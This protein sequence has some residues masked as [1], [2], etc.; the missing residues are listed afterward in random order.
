[1]LRKNLKVL[2]ARP[3][4]RRDNDEE[5]RATWLELYFDLFFVA[6]IGRVSHNF[7]HN[8]AHHFEMRYLIDMSLQFIIIWLMWTMVVYYSERFDMGGLTKR[9]LYFMM[10]FPV[11][12]IA[13]FGAENITLYAPYFFMS[14]AFA[15]LIMAVWVY[16][17]MKSNQEY[18]QVGRINM[19]TNLVTVLLIS[20]SALVDAN[21]SRWIYLLII[22]L[23]LGLPLLARN[24]ERNLSP[25]VSEKIVERLG[26]FII[27]ILGESIVGVVNGFGDNIV[28]NSPSFAAVALAIT[29]SFLLWWLYFESIGRKKPAERKS[30]TWFYSHLPLV[31]AFTGIGAI[32]SVV[33][34]DIVSVS[35]SVMYLLI[36]LSSFAVINIGIIEKF[37]DI[38]DVY[39]Q[40]TYGITPML[41]IGIGLAMLGLM[42]LVGVLAPVYILGGICA[43]LL[44]AIVYKIYLFLTHYQGGEH[45]GRY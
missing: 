42:L 11:A 1:M 19:I 36:G 29:I 35:N 13:I 28:F 33:V 31:I 27:I 21:V 10:M 24:D 44:A 5:R 6:A 40:F 9:A 26:L 39:D 43:I 12:G 18:L 32:T 41:K 25:L 14:F 22:V 30:Y 4:L 15:R 16:W 20:V 17:A 34:N 45:K 2:W 38:E 7:A 23:D 3:K 37:L 8:I